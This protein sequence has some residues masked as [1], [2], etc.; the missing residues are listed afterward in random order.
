[1]HEELKLSLETLKSFSDDVPGLGNFA[2]RALASDYESFVSVLYDDIDNIV[3]EME[4]NPELHKNDCEDRLTID[5]KKQLRAMNYD[6]SHDTKI[7]GHVDLIVKKQPK[8]WLWLGEAKIYNSYSWLRKGFRQLSTRYSPGTEN[9]NQ[10][11]MLIYI[12]KANANNIMGNWKKALLKAG[13][14]ISINIQTFPCTKNALSFY[15]T[16]PHQRTGQTY[17]VRHIPII[18]HF[19]PQ[20]N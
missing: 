2:N 12:F 5:I 20:D 1:M 9:A 13:L 18:L 14:R 16:H 4:Q 8:D 17:T 6:A 19:D 3:S 7:G 10:G 15:S 11:G